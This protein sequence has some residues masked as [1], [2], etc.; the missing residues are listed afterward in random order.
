VS[1]ATAP[2]PKAICLSLLDQAAQQRAADYL[3]ALQPGRQH[4]I[5]ERVAA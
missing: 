1:K 5:E 4:E 3:H 2:L